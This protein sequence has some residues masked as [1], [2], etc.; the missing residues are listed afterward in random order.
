[1]IDGPVAEGWTIGDIRN[2]VN[3]SINLLRRVFHLTM[4]TS[5]DQR[6]GTLDW[7]LQSESLGLHEGEVNAHVHCLAMCIAEY[8]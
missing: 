2:H 1:M 4:N 3:R 7:A 8:H 5:L 6:H